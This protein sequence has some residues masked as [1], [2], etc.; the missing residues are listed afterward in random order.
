VLAAG[1]RVYTWNLG[2][3]YHPNRSYWPMFQ[4]DLANTGVL[5]PTP[6][7]RLQGISYAVPGTLYDVD[8]GT[9]A[10]TNPRPT[11]QPLPIGLATGASG[12]LVTVSE[13]GSPAPLMSLDPLTGAA[14]A[15][16]T[17]AAAATEGDLARDPVSGALY[18]IS[19][20]GTLVTI[21]EGTGAITPLGVVPGVIESSGLAFSLDGTLHHFDGYGQKLHVLDPATG[22]VLSTTPLSPSLPI[23]KIAGM[24]Y[25]DRTDQLYVSIGAVPS[26]A[27]PALYRI[28]P[29]TGATT[30]VGPTAGVYLSGLTFSCP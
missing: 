10:L 26:P 23:Y 6:A 18:G 28:D 27:V 30:F 25:D 12:Q 9:A 17:L 2:T 14:T 8:T 20:T 19:A 16:P 4:V 13:T 7:E 15:G 11:G 29:S 22:A 1:G 21:D 5:G 24:A 3:T